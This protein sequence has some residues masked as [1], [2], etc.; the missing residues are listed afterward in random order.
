MVREIRRSV[1]LP[2]L[3]AA[4]GTA[5]ANETRPL[6]PLQFG[7]YEA[8]ATL[9]SGGMGTVYLALQTEPVL[10]QV[11]L[12][13]IR[14]DALGPD[15]IDRFHAEAQAMALANHDHVAR[16][17][18]TGTTADGTP[19]FA[20]E[21]VP[22]ESL[23]AYCESHALDVSARVRLIADVADAVQHLHD[24][25]IEH[26]DLKPDNVLV[27]ERDGVAVPKLID[28]GLASFTHAPR[29]SD[30]GLSGSFSHMAPEQFTLPEGEVD[31]RADV[32]A[33]GVMLHEVL[34]G[35]LPH[36]A[37][38]WTQPDALARHRASTARHLAQRLRG[39]LAKLAA[40]AIHP[41]REHR[42]A[43]PGRL[44]RELRAVVRTGTWRPVLVNHALIATVAAGLAAL[45]TWA[46]G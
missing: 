10:R 11:A 30:D 5:R 19:W 16:L 25:G 17:Y 7:P 41:D 22:G 43:D 38:D 34:I 31:G 15:T 18:E 28:L 3:L 33:L 32:H 23:L 13:V 1:L 37:I 40:R 26:R 45:A 20:M 44:A 36:A 27:V 35:G 29:D 4:S 42:H 24:L 21:Y 39:K 8:V 6:E 46:L 2:L 14:D 12:K 9:G